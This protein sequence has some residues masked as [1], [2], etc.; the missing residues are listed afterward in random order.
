MKLFFSWNWK[1]LA[2]GIQVLEI[3]SKNVGLTKTGGL[4]IRNW[5]ENDGLWILDMN[6]SL[7]HWAFSSSSPSSSTL[8]D[9]FLMPLTHYEE[10]QVRFLQSRFWISITEP[11]IMIY[12]LWPNP[13]SWFLVQPKLMFTVDNDV[14]VLDST[15]YVVE[16]WCSGCSADM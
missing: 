4:E 14:L 7:L 6:T 15:D 8:Y 11:R 10:Q 3:P 12:G 9:R 2:Y 13:Y 16:Q 1:S 5:G